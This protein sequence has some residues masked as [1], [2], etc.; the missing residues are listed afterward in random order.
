VTSLCNELKARKEAEEKE[1]V[2]AEAAA[3]RKKADEAAYDSDKELIP[4]KEDPGISWEA[5]EEEEPAIPRNDGE[6][7]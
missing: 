7:S 1:R 3:E 2:E 4:P 5:V 6:R